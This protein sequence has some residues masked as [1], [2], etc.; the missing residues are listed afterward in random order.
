MFKKFKNI[1]HNVFHVSVVEKG[2]GVDREE[3]DDDDDD[4]LSTWPKPKTA[5]MI[6]LIRDLPLLYD[7]TTKDYHNR[8]KKDAAMEKLADALNLTC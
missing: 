6:E 7:Y 1:V 2:T 3:D 4:D 5:E 8:V